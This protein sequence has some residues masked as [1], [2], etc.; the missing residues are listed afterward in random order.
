MSTREDLLTHLWTEVINLQLRPE[1]LAQ[2]IA[3]A[4]QRPE[5]PFADSGPALERLFALGPIPGTFAC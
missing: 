2:L 1:G 3:Y 4:K 5:D